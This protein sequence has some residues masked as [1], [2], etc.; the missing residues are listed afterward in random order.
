MKTHFGNEA[1]IEPVLLETSRCIRSLSKLWPTLGEWSSSE[2]PKAEVALFLQNIL[3]SPSDPSWNN[4]GSFLRVFCD[5]LIPIPY[6]LETFL[7]TLVLASK[8]SIEPQTY[9]EFTSHFCRAEGGTHASSVKDQI[10]DEV[11][12]ELGLAKTL[13][14]KELSS[15]HAG[16]FGDLL[17]QEFNNLLKSPELSHNDKTKMLEEIFNQLPTSRFAGE[18]VG[19]DLKVMTW[20]CRCLVR[21]V[22]LRLETAELQEMRQFQP[23]VNRLREAARSQYLEMIRL[24]SFS[25]EL[26][27]RLLEDAFENFP[28]FS[29]CQGRIINAHYDAGKNEICLHRP[30]MYLSQSQIESITYH[31]LRHFFHHTLEKLTRGTP[32]NADDMNQKLFLDF[33]GCMDRTVAKGELRLPFAQRTVSSRQLESTIISKRTEYFADYFERA[34]VRQKV[35]SHKV[36]PISLVERST[37]FCPETKEIALRIT[38]WLQLDRTELDGGIWYDP[39]AAFEYRVGLTLAGLVSDFEWVESPV[40]EPAACE[41]V[42]FPEGSNF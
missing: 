10:I 2:V 39:H 14:T 6:D 35:S 12:K 25:P 8:K 19:T 37:H 31:E 36:N 13:T 15:I 4:V 20:S 40:L 1:S 24:S 17:K 5:D 7:Y 41:M 27:D 33:I 26:K 22:E 34:V 3:R 23:Q 28:S 30:L 16:F 18:C 21:S 9:R 32:S 38:P 42:L 11:S 29:L